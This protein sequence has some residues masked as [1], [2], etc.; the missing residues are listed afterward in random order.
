MKLRDLKLAVACGVETEEIKSFNKFFDDLFSDVEIYTENAFEHNLIFIQPKTNVMFLQQ[1]LTN[2]HLSY[3]DELIGYY[4]Y[5]KCNV[6]TLEEITE[7]IKYKV[8]EIIGYL[9][10]PIT[11]IGYYDRHSMEYYKPRKL[12]LYENTNRR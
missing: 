11:Y 9:L 7:I 6:T 2:G 1:N 5:V 12:T 8:E 4:L 10:V 3:L